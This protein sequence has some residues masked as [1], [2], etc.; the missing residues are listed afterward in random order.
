VRISALASLLLVWLFTTSAHAQTEADGWAPP[1]GDRATSGD[2][3]LL[4]GRTLGVGEVMIAAGLGWPGLWAHLELAPDSNFNLGIRLGVLYGSPLMGLGIGGG[5]SAAV[6]MRIHLWGERDTDVSLRICPSAVFGEGALM[7]ES[8][9]FLTHAFG[10]AARLDAGVLVGFQPDTRVTLFFGADAGAG[11]SYVESSSAQGIGIFQGRLGVEGLLA[12]DTMMFGE[13][14][15]GGGLAP[16][17][18]GIPL[19]PDR[20]ALGVSLGL[21]YLL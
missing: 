18:P 11:V 8:T 21:G 16:D 12:R 7:G 5:G 10:F 9:G 6:P 3:S 14:T 4:S 15:V 17:R 19:Y 13:V 20:F 2:A 1:E